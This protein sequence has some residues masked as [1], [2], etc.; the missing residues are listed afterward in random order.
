MSA[1]LALPTVTGLTVGKEAVIDQ[2][3]GLIDAFLTEAYSANVNAGNVAL[4]NAQWR[5][6]SFIN[7]INATTA[8][9]TVT[10]PTIK[11][12]MFMRS[13]PA[14]TQSVDVI[15]GTVTITLAPGA[16]IWVR[17]DGTANGL[18]YVRLSGAIVEPLMFALSNEADAITNVVGAL[19]ARFPFAGTLLSVRASLNTASSSGNPTID[20]NKNGVTML[21]TKLTIDATEKTSVTAATAPVISVSAFADDDEITMDI[22]A[23]GTGAKGLKVVMYVVRAS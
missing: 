7:I 19:T 22:D 9:R 23:A 12:H 20:I 11:R 8:G 1:N 21:S 16:I 2:T 4:T 17:A 6:N 10:I 14:N 3:T 18:I 15:R 5:E 13:D